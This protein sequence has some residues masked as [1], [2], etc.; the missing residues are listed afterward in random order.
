MSSYFSESD[1]KKPNQIAH[2]RMYYTLYVAAELMM[3]KEWVGCKFLRN[4]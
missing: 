4:W 1:K 2:D 3:I